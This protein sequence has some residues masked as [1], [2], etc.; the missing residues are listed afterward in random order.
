MGAAYG[1]LPT[2][3]QL[4][5]ALALIRQRSTP[6]PDLAYF[7]VETSLAQG[8]LIVR[9]QV[10]NVEQKLLLLSGFQQFRL[11]VV[12]QV[13]VFPFRQ[14][15][16]PYAWVQTPWLD[17]YVEP[18]AQARLKTQFLLGSFLRILK[19]QGD[20]ALVQSVADHVLA[21]IHYPAVLALS[22]QQYETL[23]NY[24]SVIVQPQEA[25]LYADAALTQ[26]VYTVPAGSRLPLVRQAGE[27]WELLAPKQNGM[28]SVFV[29]KSSVR[30]FIP[31]MAFSAHELRA[32]V[33]RWLKVPYREG[34]AT[35]YGWDMAAYIQHVYRY[36][37]V[38]LVRKPEQWRAMALP[39]RELTQLKAGDIFFYAQQIGL[40]LGNDEV[41]HALPEQRRFVISSLH[42]G[43][44]RYD[45]RLRT[46]FQQ[47]ARLILNQ[48]L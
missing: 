45:R 6:D 8:K 41:L 21:W 22:E 47:G 31:G 30:L 48:G 26:A 38:L 13:E 28:R 43:D 23:L 19:T 10:G 14:F 33:R 37:G 27:V 46:E 44:P 3:E 2:Q 29:P 4:S 20:W 34:G 11:P 18:H 40:Y 24:D 1:E 16:A 9:G 12:D 17:G 7:D 35:I 39:V 15:S 36:M 5:T 25:L 32:E 42:P